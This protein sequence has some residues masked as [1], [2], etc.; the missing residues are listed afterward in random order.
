MSKLNV[1]GKNGDNLFDESARNLLKLNFILKMN[2]FSHRAEKHGITTII[3]KCQLDF[4][5][6]SPSSC[7]DL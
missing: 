3:V 7:G 1:V 5:F 4:E 2:Y 6:A